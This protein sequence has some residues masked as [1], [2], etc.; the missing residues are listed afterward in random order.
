MTIIIHYNNYRRG[1]CW[2]YAGQ[3]WRGRSYGQNSKY[4][5]FLIYVLFIKYKCL[6]LHKI[7]IYCFMNTNTSTTQRKASTGGAFT[8]FDNI[9]A[10]LVALSP[11]WLML[12]ATFF[13]S[14]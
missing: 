14:L 11:F 12:L 5:I 3:I 2:R 10:V 6:H 9:C 4:Q 8:L 7:L 13:K 1:R